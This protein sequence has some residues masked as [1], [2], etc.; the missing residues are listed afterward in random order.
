M[1]K[2]LCRS[3][4]TGEES[5]VPQHYLNHPILGQRWIEATSEDTDLGDGPV[6]LVSDAKDGNLVAGSQEPADD[7]SEGEDDAQDHR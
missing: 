5:W 6:D 2:I 4:V 3:K 7:D 1:A